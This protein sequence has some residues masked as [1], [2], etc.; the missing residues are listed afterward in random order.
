MT[1]KEAYGTMLERAPVM[2]DGIKYDYIYAVKYAYNE[3]EKTV[4]VYCELTN[5]S[6][7]SLMVVSVERVTRA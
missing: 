6:R 4:N 7:N 1:A 3:R 5:K 2:H